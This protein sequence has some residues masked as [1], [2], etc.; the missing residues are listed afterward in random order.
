MPTWNYDVLTVHGHL[1]A[2]DDSE[3]LHDLVTR[4]TDHHEQS[5]AEPWRVT[6]APETYIGG[7]LKGIVGIELTITSVEGKVKM[8]QNQPERNRYGV[9]AGL[10]DSDEQ[11][12]HAVAER[13]SSL[14]TTNAKHL[15]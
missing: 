2:H 8:S 12:D 4:L 5:R 10:R 6:D 9:V 13:V 15:G 3:W 1:L 14:G 7:Q 11:A